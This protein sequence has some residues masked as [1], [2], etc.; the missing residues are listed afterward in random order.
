MELSI[1]QDPTGIVEKGDLVSRVRAAAEVGPEGEP[2]SAPPGYTFDNAS[3]YYWSSSAQLYYDAASG[4]YYDGS[5]WYSYDN[6]SSAFVEWTA[7]AV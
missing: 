7:S 5:K 3:G 4:G 6:D 2:S 1:S